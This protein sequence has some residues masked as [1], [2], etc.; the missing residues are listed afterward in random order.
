MD[1][2]LLLAP[3]IPFSA[4]A[5][6]TRHLMAAPQRRQVNGNSIPP[7]LA[8]EA[9]KVVNV[10]ANFG[11]LVQPVSGQVGY[12]VSSLRCVVGDTSLGQRVYTSKQPELAWAMESG[13]LRN[14]TIEPRSNQLVVR[15]THPARDIVNLSSLFRHHPPTPAKFVIGVDREDQPV[16][17]PLDYESPHVAIVGTTGSGKTIA[18]MVIALNGLYAGNK[19]IICNPKREP[20]DGKRRRLSDFRQSGNLVYATEPDAI[21][22]AL[23]DVRQSLD[24]QERT[25]ILIDEAPIL[26]ASNPELAKAAGEIAQLGRDFDTHLALAAT[27]ITKGLLIDT[28]L[29]GNVATSV[30]GLHVALHRHSYSASGIPQLGLGELAGRGDAQVVIRGKATRTQIAWPNNYQR[31][32][33][34]GG[35][36]EPDPIAAITHEWLGSHSVGDTVS[37]AA[38]QRYAAARGE[39]KNWDYWR[40]QYGRLVAEGRVEIGSKYQ[41]GKRIA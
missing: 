29:Q 23:R 33:V 10:Y 38:L 12:Q 9:Q 7:Q 30:I 32:L 18:L 3:L 20:G 5:L 39:G 31:Y 6:A 16:W 28:M 40:D 13:K 15:W 14:L 26:F 1:W 8:W 4:A 41:G 34:P 2:L 25:L 11:L 19:V 27:E 24:K 22:F 36:K 35:A 37:I 21:A 17:L